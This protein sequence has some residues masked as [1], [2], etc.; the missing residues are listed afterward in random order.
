[1]TFGEVATGTAA[2]AILAH[3]VAIGDVRWTKGRVLDAADVA[4]AL[5]AGVTTL[6]VARPGP[7]D[8]G[9][10]DAAATLAA[11]FAGPGTI[12]AAAAHGRANLIAAA[13]G[14]FG[15]DAAAVD[16]VNAV[17]ERLTIGTL[18]PLTRVAA[19][20][21]VATVKV[22]PYAVAAPVLAA[23][24]AAAAHVTVSAFAARR[25][26]LIQSRLERTPDKL[27]ARTE[28]VTRDRIVALGGTLAPAAE[29]RHD[30]AALAAAIAAADPG[31][32][33]LIAGASA[34]ADRRD[35]IPAAIV[36]A[37]GTVERMGM[38]VD[39]GNLLCLGSHAGRPVIGL[40]GCARS[41]KRNGFDWVLERLVA[42]LPV[43]GRDIAAMGVGGLLP[44]AE[45]PQPRIVAAG[46]MVGAIVLAAGRST[47][48]GAANKLLA[49]LG[50]RPVVAHVVDAIAAAGLP[51]PVV[52]VG[53]TRGRG[54][55]RARRAARD[56]RHRRRLRRRHEPVAARGTRRGAGGV[57]RGDRRARRH[58]G[59]RSG[60]LR[61]AGGGGTRPDTRRRPDMARQAR[62]PGR[63]GPRA[64]A[65]A[66]GGDRRRRRPRAAERARRPG[67]RGRGRRPRHPCRRRHARGVG[68]AARPDRALVDRLPAD[69]DP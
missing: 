67:P 7:G 60:D 24:V 52:V 9:E 51:P 11:A 4:A 36:A 38:P 46:A 16:A 26:V 13:A 54:R 61:R 63:L 44:E 57:G 5:A 32:I 37:G 39:P 1:M 50:G 49:D 48:M 53:H 69:C 59:G 35:V 3:S 29:C 6:T 28:A 17:D 30:T 19:G 34:T 27:L 43:D 41:P 12:A 40:P 45:R 62:Q 8:I 23:A 42:G 14:L 31:A 20:E 25:F 33:V 21:V 18:A 22:I 15:V 64:L 2:G 68:G 58:A 47:R 56:H 10:N 55:R 66:G 65:A